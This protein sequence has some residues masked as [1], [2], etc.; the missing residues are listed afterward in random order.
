MNG[1]QQTWD[2]SNYVV[3]ASSEPARI[4]LAF[5]KFFP[6]IRVLPQSVATEFIAGYGDTPDKVPADIR[7]AIKMLIAHWYENREAVIAELR[8]T[9]QQMPLAVETLLWNHRVFEF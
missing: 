9:P 7:H 6:P 4:G 1:V 3:D 2:P 8:I 5:G